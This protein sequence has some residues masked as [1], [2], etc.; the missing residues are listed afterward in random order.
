MTQP[1][2]MPRPPGPPSPPV[3]PPQPALVPPPPLTGLMGSSNYLLYSDCNPVL[4][5]SVTIDVTEDIV[6]ESASGAS[7]N[8]NPAAETLGFGFQLNG[9]SPP[10]ETSAWQQY[11]IVLAESELGGM[12][13][14]WPV[15]LETETTFVSF[16]A[17][18]A[19]YQ[20]PLWLILSGIP[21]VSVPKSAVLPAGY[22]LQISLQNALPWRT[23][24]DLAVTGSWGGGSGL[25]LY[26][27]AAG[28]GATYRVD[29][30][31][32]WYTLAQSGGWRTT[33]DLAVTGG[34]GDAEGTGLL[35]YDRAA[36]FGATYNVDSN[37]VWHLL[38]QSGGWRTSWDLA[39]AGSWGGGSGLLLYDRAAG[40]GATY[41]V[42]S[43]GVWHL[44]AQSGDWRTSW[45]LAVTG[46]W[47]D[48]GS[49]LLLY[50]RAAGFAA[51]YTVGSN[52]E[53]SDPLAQYDKFG[54]SWD[55][56]VTGKWGDGTSGLLLYDRAAGHAEFHTVDRNGVMS[57][58]LA[59]YDD[60]RTSWDLAVTG[61]WGGAGGSGLLLYD[62]AAGLGAFYT[63]D[64]SRWMNPLQQSDGS[65]IGAT[66]VVTDNHGTVS[67]KTIDL[68]SLEAT[69][70]AST[71]PA[72]A[73]VAVM[74]VDLAPIVAFEL[75]L[76]GPWNGETVVLASGAGTITYTASTPLTVLNQLPPCV[77]VQLGGMIDTTGEN[78]N[79]VY[80]L[81]PAAPSNTITQSFSV[82][83]APAIRK[84]GRPGH[85]L[86][87]PPGTW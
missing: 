17:P 75:D 42:D 49:G 57:L 73:P 56:A 33:W 12:V 67:A 18:A 3:A 8:G 26:D 62:R 44:L 23:S 15:P 72:T 61:G 78:A 22:R 31:G 47:G 10:N 35:L 13:N 48:G 63:V 19:G 81:L 86:F 52:G 51:L 70:P 65:V 6:C 32:V 21:V 7:I 84:P 45:D 9:Y 80:G 34:W 46:D 76:V 11:S 16:N 82:T 54:T 1:P 60:W 53:L 28:V 38:A 14:N 29:S 79:S 24:W 2:A 37:G 4:D 66:Y 39:V 85:G 40:F 43:N 68:Y 41:R 27:R 50:D 59:Q 55:L 5:L 25:L 77:D 87:V 74:A 69:P 20:P 64:S 30:N 36:G 71:P 83:Q 58:A